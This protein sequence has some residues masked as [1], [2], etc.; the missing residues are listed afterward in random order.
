MEAR[1]LVLDMGARF[2]I[3]IQFYLGVYLAMAG[4]GTFFI[5]CLIL[6]YIPLK[7]T[8][9]QWICLSLLVTI[10]DIYV[11]LIMFPYSYI[12]EQSKWQLKRL[13]FIKSLLQRL[14]RDE[15]LLGSNVKRIRQV[16]VQKAVTFLQKETADIKDRDE[17][18]EKM[19][20]MAGAAMDTCNEAIDLLEKELDHRPQ[21]LLGLTMYPER[22]TGL[23]TTG[24][25]FG[26]TT[27]SS[28]LGM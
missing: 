4:L 19:L 15:R 12:N 18:Q 21:Q 16:I 10:L 2:V 7:L 11:I 28:K 17:R 20:E 6:G 9:I 3:R 23:L 14:T 25:L 13:V 1:K 5:I 8:I 27:L 24:F 26:F 22:I